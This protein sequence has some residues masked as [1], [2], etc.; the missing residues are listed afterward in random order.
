MISDT[1]CKI[2]GD[3]DKVKQRWSEYYEKHF[4]LKDGMTAEKSGQCA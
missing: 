4:E 2:V 1:E 3:K